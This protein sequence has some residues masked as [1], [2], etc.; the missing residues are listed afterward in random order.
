MI[1]SKM[2][3]FLIAITIAVSGMQI[4]GYQV[5][6][7]IIVMM[8]VDFLTLGALFHLEKAPSL[9]K[10]NP[11]NVED[12]IVPR[13]KKIDKLDAIEENSKNI[14]SQLSNSGFEDKLKKQS[15]D[16]TYLLDKMGRKTL[17]LE[18]RI[19]KFGNGLLDSLTNLNKRVDG[20]EKTDEKNN[21]F[22]S[23]EFVYLKADEKA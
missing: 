15:D 19:N 2:F 10:N 22:S 9:I 4:L 18:E 11:I 8:V 20:L 23:N 5:L 14:L 6:E 17:E 3:L 12:D 7:L 16:I 1:L 13:L 21:Q